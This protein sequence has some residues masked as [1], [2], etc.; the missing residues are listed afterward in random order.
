M[1]ANWERPAAPAPMN[2]TQAS[3]LVSDLFPGKQVLQVERIG[4]GLSNSNYIIRFSGMSVPYILRVYR[5]GA[6][7]AEKEQAIHQLLMNSAP[8]PQILYMD[9]SCTRL[10]Q[11][12]AVLEWM[13]GK[14]LRDVLQNG[15]ADEI[16]RCAASAGAA[17]A[18]IHSHQFEE[19][20]FFGSG[21]NIAQRIKMDADTF[22]AFI[23]DSLEQ[24]NAGQYLGSGIARR[25]QE[26]C[27]K[28]APY[29]DEQAGKPVLVHSDYN[30]LNILFEDGAVSA[31]LD[32][33][34]AYSGSRL[35]DIGNMLRYE[36]PDSIFE[37]AFIKGYVEAGGQ[38][39]FNWRMLARLEDLV[40]LCDL[41]NRSTPAMP[42]RISDLKSLIANSI[43]E[44][45]LCMG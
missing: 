17:L 28:L 24:Q 20:G 11:P 3:A 29:L 6:W 18:Q 21:L 13:P 32:W 40:A 15:D 39:P 31:V 19:P 34:F 12:Y 45:S 8:V 22:T 41:L 7:I 33:E 1:K 4:T 5:E 38:L 35:C 42:N 16:S 23:V 44:L 43:E 26:C 25:L 27:A 14:L 36:K 37:Q 2:Q 10:S 9:A 30:G